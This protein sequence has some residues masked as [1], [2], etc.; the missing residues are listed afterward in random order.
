L[1]SSQDNSIIT[2]EDKKHKIELQALSIELEKFYHM[3][4][5]QQSI[6]RFSRYSNSFSDASYNTNYQFSNQY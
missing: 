3:F 6:E 5:D 2:C 4:P 1:F